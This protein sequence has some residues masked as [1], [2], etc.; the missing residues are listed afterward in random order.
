MKK[1]DVFAL[2]LLLGTALYFGA[3]VAAALLRPVMPAVVNATSR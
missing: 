3:H 1:D 2:L